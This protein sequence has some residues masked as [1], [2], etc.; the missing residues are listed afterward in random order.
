MPIWKPPTVSFL[1]AP[2]RD[3]D[4]TAYRAMAPTPYFFRSM[5]CASTPTLKPTVVL[6]V[7]ASAVVIVGPGSVMVSEGIVSCLTAKIVGP[8]KMP[9]SILLATGIIQ[10]A[11]RWTA[12][13]E[14]FRPVNAFVTA[15]KAPKTIGSGML[16][17]SD[18]SDFDT[19]WVYDTPASTLCPHT[20]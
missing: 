1:A 14:C 10:I 6:L 13:S 5:Y 7:C 17:V 11:S 4:P 20:L 3:T 19:T 15:R 9:T 2:G 8:A 12:F 18:P 16:P